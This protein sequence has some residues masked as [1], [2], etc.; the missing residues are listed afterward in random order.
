M[1]ENWALLVDLFHWYSSYVIFSGANILCQLWIF[2]IETINKLAWKST[3]KPSLRFR[4]SPVYTAVSLV[5]LLTP[6]AGDRH[7][8]TDRFVL[9]FKPVF[10]QKP[11]MCWMRGDV[12]KLDCADA[13]CTGFPWEVWH[14][15][16]SLFN[17]RGHAWKTW[18]Q[19]NRK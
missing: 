1:F 9:P 19:T 14:S 3:Q 10:F 6:R 15:Q 5:I 7:G 13:S 12:L 4:V 11:R 16:T 17:T 8:H 2:K 18:S